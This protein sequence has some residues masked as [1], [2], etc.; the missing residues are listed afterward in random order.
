MVITREDS[1]LNTDSHRL[2][3]EHPFFLL[4]FE[5]LLSEHFGQK[6]IGS[7]LFASSLRTVQDYVLGKRRGTGK[8]SVS[9]SWRKTW[10][11]SG[12]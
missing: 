6:G 11:M 1:V 10:V 7:G 9:A 12:W 3:F 4:Q 5:N 2:R 8:S